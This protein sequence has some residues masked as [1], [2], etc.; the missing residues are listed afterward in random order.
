MDNKF[1]QIASF[2]ETLSSETVL[3]ENEEALLLVGGNGEAQKTNVDCINSPCTNNSC[4]NYFCQDG[5]CRNDGCL[6]D[7]CGDLPE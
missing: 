1:K 6:N 3:N 5:S 7:N 2:L 4:I